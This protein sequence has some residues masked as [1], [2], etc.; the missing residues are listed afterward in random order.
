MPIWFSIAAASSPKEMSNHIGVTEEFFDDI[1]L[2]LIRKTYVQLRKSIDGHKL[3]R[4]K[5]TLFFQFSSRYFV[6][7]RI[8]KYNCN[9]YYRIPSV[10]NTNKKSISIHKNAKK[11]RAFARLAGTNNIQ[12]QF[13]PPPP[14]FRT[15]ARNRSFYRLNIVKVFFVAFFFVFLARQWNILFFF[16]LAV[17]ENYENKSGLT[18]ARYTVGDLCR[19]ALLRRSALLCSTRKVLQEAR[20][21]VVAAARGKSSAR[22][23]RTYFA[24]LPVT[25]LVNDGIFNTSRVPVSKVL[26]TRI[27]IFRYENR[28]KVFPVKIRTS[29]LCKSWRLRIRYILGVRPIVWFPCLALV[30]ELILHRWYKVTTIFGFPEQVLLEFSVRM[31]RHTNKSPRLGKKTH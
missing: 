4:K 19:R 3:C 7:S 26:P 2:L 20:A 14:L 29:T 31:S 10:L 28:R 24:C 11:P 23:I 13:S 27:W 21:V 18:R 30:F 15:R 25:G 9:K 17:P 5:N 22:F 6:C 1:L 12:I 8:R 16:F